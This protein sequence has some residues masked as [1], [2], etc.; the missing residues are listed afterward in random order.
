MAKK[1]IL[2]SFALRAVT[3]TTYAAGIERTDETTST[4][5]SIRVVQSGTK[6]NE[7][8]RFPLVFVG[9]WQKALASPKVEKMLPI[10][11]K[12]VWAEGPLVREYRDRDDTDEPSSVLYFSD[13]TTAIIYRLLGRKRLE[14]WA[15]HAGGIDPTE[16]P[17]LAEPG[18]NG[19]ATD[20]LDGEFV[21]INQHGLRRVIK[22][23]LD[24]HAPGAPL[25][26]CPDFEVIADSFTDQEKNKFKLNSPNDVIVHP[27][28]GSVWFTDP[29]YGLLEKERFCD[30]WNCE[31]HGSYLDE[32][33]ETGWKGVYRF[34]RY[35]KAVDLVARYHRR[36]NGLAFSPDLKTLWIADSTI[37]NPSLTSYDIVVPTATLDN[38]GDGSDGHNYGKDKEE[39]HDKKNIRTNA[40]H[41][42]LLYIDTKA[43]EILNS[44]TLGMTLGTTEGL[45][46]LT[47]GEGVTDGIK[48]DPDTKYIWTSIPN[49]V[50]V[51]NPDS[52][53]VICQILL[54]I[55]TS[56][57]AF[58]DKGEVW[59]TGA[60]GIWRVQKSLATS[61]ISK[62]EEL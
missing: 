29:I 13:T 4:D 33:S 60:R 7:G 52:K 27:I 14:V 49:G 8:A 25:S 51:I 59:L 39:D 16:H 19:M 32:K 22:C 20:E 11:H 40:N 5:A 56:N 17:N 12:V 48:I 61:S 45:P 24:D 37:G 53:E 21:V 43:K 34:D 42:R 31:R 54:G 44:A 1:A 2:L 26:E 36:P 46:H 28:D 57:V 30:E 15:I 10:D 62:R 18:S 41:R 9:N 47:G 55:N 6:I 23:R 58:G 3:V 35:T 38:F 50:A